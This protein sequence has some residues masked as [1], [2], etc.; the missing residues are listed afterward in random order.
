MDISN[1]GDKTEFVFSAALEMTTPLLEF[2]TNLP[3]NTPPAGIQTLLEAMTILA[4]ISSEVK[5]LSQCYGVDVE[6][7][8][9]VAPN[10]SALAQKLFAW[11]EDS[12]MEHFMRFDYTSETFRPR[13][14]D[15]LDE[16]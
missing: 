9:G 7:I 5:E 11:H 1:S 8:R 10:A 3:A 4:Q 16:W 6:K 2:F 13:L 15:E 12:D 14:R